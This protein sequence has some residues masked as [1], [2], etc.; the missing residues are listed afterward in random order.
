MDSPF[1]TTIATLLAEQG[2]ATSRFEFA[3]MAARRNGG[4]KRPPPKAEL[5]IG[6]YKAAV[7][8]C[9]QLHPGKRLF[10]GGKSMGG[11]VASMAADRL[12]AEGEIAGVVCLGYPFHPPNKP[13]ELR[14]AHLEQTACPMLIVQGERDPFGGSADVAALKLSRS[15]AFHWA[16]DGDHDLGPR[17]GKGFTRRGNLT[18]AAVAIARWIE[19]THL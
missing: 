13:A 19:R 2:V 3:Y 15:I 5:L 4:K 12:H 1:M 18:E 6:E 8:A 9:A 10:I 11:R 16:G 14:V 17:G 7:R